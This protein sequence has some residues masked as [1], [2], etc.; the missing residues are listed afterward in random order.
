M[1]YSV[2]LIDLDFLFSFSEGSCI[3]WFAL[4]CC[5]DS[6]LEPDIKCSLPQPLLSKVMLG[7]KIL[8]I[9]IAVF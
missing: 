5:S 8:G 2:K 1:E 7:F 4:P 6:Y 9:E 3:I